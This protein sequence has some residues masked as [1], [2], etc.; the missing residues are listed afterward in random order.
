MADADPDQEAVREILRYFVRNPQAADDLEGIAR[1]RLLDELVTRR[2]EQTERA[3]DWLV[4]RGYLCATVTAGTGP[5]FSSNPEKAAE[6]REFL[7]AST[8]R[9]SR[10]KA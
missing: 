1:W 5:I 4:A 2:L 7:A 3:L 6:A 9:G 10:E 8:P